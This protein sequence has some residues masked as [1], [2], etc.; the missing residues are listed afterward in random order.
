MQG[1]SG[2][3]LV[4]DNDCSFCEEFQKHFA[5]LGYEVSTAVNASDT[6]Q[7]CRYSMPE[8]IFVSISA[9]K[10]DGMELLKNLRREW[11][12]IKIVAMA[13]KGSLELVSRAMETK[14]FEYVPKPRKIAFLDALVKRALQNRKDKNK[15][16]PKAECGFIGSSEAMQSIFKHLLQIAEQD[17]PVLISGSTG[18]GKELAARLIHSKS[19]RSRGPFIPVN[20]GA[21]PEHLVESELFGH[22]KGSFTG[23]IQD[24]IGFCEAADNGILFLDELGEL[25]LEAQVK[26]L[27]FLDSRSVERIG[28][29]TRKRVNVRILAAT[30]KNLE[31]AINAGTFRLD[32]FY[33]IA[34]LNI[35]MPDLIS[36]K[37]DIPELACFFL[38]KIKPGMKLAPESLEELSRR[39]WP[40]NVRE[41]RNLLWQASAM[42]NGSILTPDCFPEES[43]AIDNWQDAGLQSFVASRNWGEGCLELA[44]Q[45][46]QRRLIARAINES[47]G[48]QS[49][50]ANKLGIH[51]NTL[52]RLLEDYKL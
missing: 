8:V 48:N 32:L 13:T 38:D 42:A 2:H 28:D 15:V 37:E 39:K 35:R 10:D 27:R 44:T 50:A 24:K 11:Q 5:S 16:P 43:N 12:S 20:C 29:T 23:A 34:V 36:H 52:H 51:R 22:C 6:L 14:V 45:E 33:R 21:L 25:P 31:E 18:T 40:G 26:L 3:I 47:E 17:A 19:S 46:L 4:V 1:K 49:L 9:D 30:N 7:I 41:L